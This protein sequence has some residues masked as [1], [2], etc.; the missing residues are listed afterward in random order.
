AF[1]NPKQGGDGDGTLAGWPSAQA[2]SDVI[3]LEKEI[4]VVARP[5]PVA[6]LAP[7]LPRVAAP[8]DTSLTPAAST[9]GT[10]SAPSS[11]SP[12]AGGAGGRP[13]GC[14]SSTLNITSPADGSS[15]GDRLTVTVT[16]DP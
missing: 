11:D 3:F 13:G 15:A 1:A 4:P 6:E 5:A 8:A 10:K 7:V 9:G 16:G 14:A 12:G 2:Q